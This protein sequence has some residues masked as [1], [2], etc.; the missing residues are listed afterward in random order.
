MRLALPRLCR[1]PVPVSL[2]VLAMA[3]AMMWPDRSRETLGFVIT[4]FVD[5][6]PMIVPGLL[7]AAWVTASGAGDVTA[8]LFRG[9]PALLIVVASAIGALTPVCGVS[10][11]PLMVGFLA[12]GVPLAPVMA[13]WLSSPVTDP[14]LFAATWAL[15]GP[16]FAIGKTAAA[17]G[18]GLIAGA[19]TAALGATA[20]VRSP[21]RRARLPGCGQART[22]PA[23]SVTPRIWSEPT[24]MR[25]FRN[26]LLSTTRLVAACLSVAFAAEH[27]LRDLLP[28]GTLA[29]FVGSESPWAIPVA[30]TI[31]APLYLDGYAALPLI[32]GL[33]DLGM[34]AGAALTFLVSGSA[35]S[36][37]GVLAIMPVLRSPTVALYVAFSLVGS[38]TAGYVFEVVWTLLP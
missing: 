20:M 26:E 22:A 23:T 30:A 21:L 8:A 13:F 25:V 37:W 12:A 1:S 27:L 7:L 28:A 32:R 38:L 19:G 36:I 34:S 9:R 31:G 4:S 5:V 2:V 24:R 10:V 33:L 14:G 35:V 15:L 11:L 3:A 17:F 16:A 6:A 29:G 18:I